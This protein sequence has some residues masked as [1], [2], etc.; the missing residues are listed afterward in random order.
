MKWSLTE[1]AIA[2]GVKISVMGTIQWKWHSV[3]NLLYQANSWWEMFSGVK[4]RGENPVEDH[5]ILVNN[6]C[7]FHPNHKV[8]PVPVIA[9]LPKNVMPQ[10]RRALR[11]AFLLDHT[12]NHRLASAD[13]FI[14]QRINYQVIIHCCLLLSFS[15]SLQVKLS[16]ISSHCSVRFT[17]SRRNFILEIIWSLVSLCL[18]DE[19]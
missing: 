8:I 15:P 14:F 4:V 1:P 17:A 5:R 19:L 7:N 12:Q 13:K 11:L 9:E 6:C 10:Y 3:G 18:P 2:G 16:V